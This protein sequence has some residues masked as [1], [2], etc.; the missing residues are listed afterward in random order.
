M[1]ER[2]QWSDDRVVLGD[3]TFMLEGRAREGAKDALWLHKD[4]DLLDEY[5]RLFAD[6]PALHVRNMVELGIWKGGSVALWMELLQ[7]TKYVALDLRKREDAPAFSRYVEAHGRGGRLRTY[8]GTDQADGPRLL[9][10]VATEFDGPLDFVIDDAS[11]AYQPTRASFETLFPLL[12]EGGLYVI[13]DWPWKFAAEF[14]ADFPASEPGLLPLIPDLAILLVGVRGLIRRLE[15]RTPF[16]VV[17]RG[18]AGEDAARGGIAA[19]W[20]KEPAPQRA[21]PWLPLRRVK[22]SMARAVRGRQ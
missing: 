11:H 17:Q 20:H 5:E 2:L 19:L 4:R 1:F 6:Y 3:I 21:D 14:Q 8:W 10:I 13:E 9:E 15:V 12:A 22:R 7:P 16:I 18:P